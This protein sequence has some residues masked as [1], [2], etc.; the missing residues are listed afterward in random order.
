MEFFCSQC[1]K[2]YKSIAGLKRH[3]QIAHGKKKAAT[4]KPT[5]KA[6]KKGYAAHKKATVRGKSMAEIRQVLIEEMS[7]LE[8]D[9][10]SMLQGMGI[11]Y[12]SQYQIGTKFFDFYL[13]DHNI[14]IEVDGDYHHCNPEIYKKPQNATQRRAIKNDN[15]KNRLCEEKGIMLLRIWENDFRNR[16]DLVVAKIFMALNIN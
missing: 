2:R 4:K 10:M 7:Q 11:N 15:H 16:R 8:K 12:V 6:P 5:K 1:S 13:P 14:I 3:K 9:F